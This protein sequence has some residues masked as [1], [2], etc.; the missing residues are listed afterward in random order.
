MKEICIPEKFSKTHD[1]ED[2]VFYDSG[3][4]D[5]EKIIVFTTE[6]SM[7]LLR[8]SEFWHA[9]GT[10]K[11]APSIFYQLFIYSY[12]NNS[13]LPLVYALL[14]NKIESTYERLFNLF[15]DLMPRSITIDFELAIKSAIVKIFPTCSINYCLF[16][17]GQSINRKVN[18]LGLSTRYGNDPEFKL[19]CKMLSALVFLPVDDVEMGYKAIE[20]NLEDEE[21]DLILDY[22][23]EYYIG[24]F[25]LNKRKPPRF[26][27]ESWNCFKRFETGEARTDNGAESFNSV[28]ANSTVDTKH[29]PFFTL[30]GKLQD[31]QKM[32]ELK[33]AKLRAGSKTYKKVKCHSM[34]T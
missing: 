17:L 24:Q 6:K 33:I 8:R 14:P 12:F 15:S 10:F 4:N 1:G 31:E 27:V 20:N 7:D 21:F 16:H 25:A 13:T 29:P 30:L 18:S 5:E 34:T 9:D 28:F 3:D 32:T 11:V 2:F 19:H 26:A 22:F 23:E